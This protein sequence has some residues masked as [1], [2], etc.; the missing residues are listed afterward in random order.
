MQLERKRH[1][2]NDIVVIIF[3]EG[4]YPFDPAC[5]LSEFNRIDSFFSSLWSNNAQQMSF[6]LFLLT[7]VEALKTMCTTGSLLNIGCA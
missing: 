3:D 1:I 7:G 4:D 2:G 5:I 6:L